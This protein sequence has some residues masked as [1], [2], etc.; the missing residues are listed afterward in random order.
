MKD[1]VVFHKFTK[2]EDVILQKIL[3]R[4]K[5]MFG[6]LRTRWDKTDLTMTISAAIGSNEDI[7]ID[8]EKLLNFDNFSFAH[9]ISGLNHNVNHETGKLMN[10]FLPRCAR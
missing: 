3:K 4:A 8:L 9:D 10:C 2:K 5:K 1:Y 6:E 7:T